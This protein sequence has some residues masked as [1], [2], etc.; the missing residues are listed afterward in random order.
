M[1]AYLAMIVAH[2]IP[3]FFCPNMPIV[4]HGWQR[5]WLARG[6]AHLQTALGVSKV[7]NG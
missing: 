7:E 2:A 4:A 6:M 3:I 5:E 1:A